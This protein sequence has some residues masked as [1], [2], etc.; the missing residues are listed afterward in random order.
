MFRNFIDGFTAY[1]KAWQYIRDLRLWGYFLIPALISIVLAIGVGALAWSLSDNVGAWL[2]GWIPWGGKVVDTLGRIFGGLLVGA[3]GLAVFRTLVL[4][5]AGPFMSPLS[6][7]IEAYMSGKPSKGGFQPG[8]IVR[9]MLRGIGLSLRN[10]LLEL[11]FTLLLIVLGLAIPIL[12]PLIPVFIFVVQAFYAGFG[13][14][15]FTLERHFG[16]RDSVRFARHFRWL[17]IGN[18]AAYLLLLFT[19]VG[20]LVALPLGTA[21]ATMETVERIERG[22]GF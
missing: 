6:E 22:K 8:R 19:G 17:A 3:A 5:L 4:I 13:N 18:G 9:E 11:L 1:T 16:Y 2:I 21:A 20:F 10:L 15:D 12:A 14:M 7:K